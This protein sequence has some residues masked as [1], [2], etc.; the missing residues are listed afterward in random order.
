MSTCNLSDI[1]ATFPP[2][3]TPHPLDNLSIVYRIAQFSG[4][5]V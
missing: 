1:L 5:E 4:P 3:G 2:G